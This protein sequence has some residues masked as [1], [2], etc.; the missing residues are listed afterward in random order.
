MIATAAVNV[1]SV[2]STRLV[3]MVHSRRRARS[4]G[5][6]SGSLDVHDLVGSFLNFRADL[7]SEVL[8]CGQ[9]EQRDC[10][11]KDDHLDELAA[12]ARVAKKLNELGIDSLHRGPLVALRSSGFGFWN[13]SLQL[14]QG[15]GA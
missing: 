2:K 10:D 5:E 6:S 11:D 3:L 15:T 8:V 9:A 12:A 14:A 7:R 4:S 1:S 13:E